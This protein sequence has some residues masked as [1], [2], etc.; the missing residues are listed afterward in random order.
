MRLTHEDGHIVIRNNEGILVWHKHIVD[1]EKDAP[2]V[3]F[4][5]AI[6][7][8]IYNSDCFKRQ[9]I[10]DNFPLEPSEII[11]NIAPKSDYP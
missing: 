11:D 7:E 3:Y 1:L 5:G 6:T 9:I 2:E 10:A 8:R 4:S